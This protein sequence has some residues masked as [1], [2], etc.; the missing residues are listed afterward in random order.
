MRT[1]ACL[2]QQ[3]ASRYHVQRVRSASKQPRFVSFP[4]RARVATIIGGGAALTFLAS[5]TGGFRP[6]DRL[7]FVGTNA[8]LMMVV[9]EVLRGSERQL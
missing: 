8:A 5:S 7:L 3:P 2:E 1:S 9:S 4:S 6:T